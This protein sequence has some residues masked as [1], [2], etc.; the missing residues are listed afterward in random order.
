MRSASW[1]LS[2][3]TL[4]LLLSL[5]MGILLAR[6]LGPAGKGSLTV[7]QLIATTAMVLAALGTP[8]ALNFLAARQEVSGQAAVRVAFGFAAISTLVAVVLAVALG[9]WAAPNLFHVSSASL[10]V[11]GAVALAP[12]MI[13]QFMG[14]YLIG[15][16]AVRTASIVNIGALSAQLVGY[17]G[18]ALAGRLTPMT[19]VAVWLVATVGLAVIDSI[20]AWRY[21]WQG[22]LRTGFATV[23]RGMSYALASWATNGLS[24]LALRADMFFLAFFLG[25]TAVGVYSIAVTLAELSWYV[26]TALNSVLVPKVASEGEQSSLDVTLRLTRTVWPF[27]LAVSASVCLASVVAVPILFGAPFRASVLALVAITPGIVF[28]AIGSLPGAYLAGIGRPI[29]VTKSTLANLVVNVVANLALIPILG[30]VGA[31]LAS[32][33]SYGTGAIVVVFLFVRH[34]EVRLSDVLLPR[35][36]DFRDFWAAARNALRVRFPDRVMLGE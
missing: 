20:I 26:P 8:S 30:V 17:A 28:S 5:P 18:L 4:T 25:T 35:V 2:T 11:L 12:V 16:G 1:L 24:L 15:A 19:A 33:L 31:S 34:T 9:S 6:V 14:S 10:V 23:R 13:G 22:A 27:T 36:D 3:Q 7:V 21:D 29:D 32:S